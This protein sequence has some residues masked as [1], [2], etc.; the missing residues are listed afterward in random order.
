MRGYLAATPSFNGPSATTSAASGAASGSTA[1]APQSAPLGA[2][3]ASS[4]VRWYEE[5]KEAAQRGDVVRCC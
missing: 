3:I 4:V 1:R 5:A 2:V